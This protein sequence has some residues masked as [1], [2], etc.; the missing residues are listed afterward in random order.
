MTDYYQLLGVARD[1]SDDDIKRAYRQV[2]L[3]F[4][5]DRNEGSKE[6]EERFKEVTRAYEVLRDPD[7]RSVYDRYGEEGLARGAGGAQGFDF[8]DPLEVFMRDFGGFGGLGDLFGRQG[9]RSRGQGPERGQSLKVS[10]GL[11][12]ADVVKGAKRTLKVQA[13]NACGLCAGSG[14]EP[15]TTANTCATCGGTGEEQLVQRSVFGQLVSVQPCRACRGQGQVIDTPCRRCHGEGRE[16][17]ESEVEVEIPAGVSS[18]NYITLRGRGNAGP[19]GGARGDLV[20]LLGVEDDPRFVR[21]GSELL[22]EL[23]VTVGQAAARGQDQGSHAW[24]AWRGCASPREPRAASSSGCAGRGCRSWAPLAGAIK[25]CAWSCGCRT[26]SPLSRSVSTCSS[27]R[28]RDPAPERI[29]DADRGGFWSRVK[30]AFR[31]V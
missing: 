6:S 29:A 4:H 5:P 24:T 30:E 2:A 13:L 9:H 7:K 11:T 10:L 22:Y 31:A 23:P 19:R 12:L 8:S 17:G 14:A 25:S 20:V 21:D 16:R 1:A 3:K 27:R 26:D 15:G 28:S 18:E